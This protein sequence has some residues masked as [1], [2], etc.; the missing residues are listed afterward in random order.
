MIYNLNAFLF[1]ASISP[2]VTACLVS[3]CLTLLIEIHPINNTKVLKAVDCRVKAQVEVKRVNLF[4]SSLT[5]IQP[6]QNYKLISNC[7]KTFLITTPC[8]SIHNNFHIL[9]CF[10]HKPHCIRSTQFLSVRK[11]IHD[12]VNK[13]K[14]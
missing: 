5:W 12:S 10:K 14:K 6:L 11:R 8:R 13:K 4:L 7:M 2:I 1:D 9:S 3:K